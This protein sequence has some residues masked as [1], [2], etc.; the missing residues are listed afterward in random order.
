MP[1]TE[2]QTNDSLINAPENCLVKVFGDSFNKFWNKALKEELEGVNISIKKDDEGKDILVGYITSGW[3]MSAVFI[4]RNL[5]NKFK[6]YR[7]VREQADSVTEFTTEVAM[8]IA[9]IRRKE[10]LWSKVYRELE[11]LWQFQEVTTEQ[12]SKKGQ[13]EARNYQVLS[14]E[15]TAQKNKSDNQSEGSTVVR[16]GTNIAP[17]GK[18][19]SACS[20]LEIDFPKYYKRLWRLFDTYASPSLEFVIDPITGK[21]K[22]VTKEEF[23]EIVE[24]EKKKDKLKDTDPWILLEEYERTKD[25]AKYLKALEIYHS[26]NQKE[27]D[28]LPETSNRKPRI[29]NR[30]KIGEGLV[31][32]YESMRPLPS[33][34][35]F[36]ERWKGEVEGS[37]KIIGFKE[38]FEPVRKWLKGWHQ[39]NKYLGKVKPPRQLMIALLGSPGLGKTYISQKIAEVLGRGFGIIALNGRNSSD[40]IFGSNISNP[41]SDPGEIVKALSRS[42][43]Q[44][45][46][47]LLDEIDKAGLETKQAIGNPTD[48]TQNYMFKDDFYDFPT[49]LDQV[50]FLA[51][52]NYPEQ[53]PDFVADRFDIKITVK[54]YAYSERIEIAQQL[55]KI[56]LK[57]LEFLIQEVLHKTWEELYQ[58][59]N[60]EALLKKALT[61]TYS[62]RGLKDNIQ[63][64]LLETLKTEFLDEDDLKPFPSDLINHNWGFSDR[65]DLDLGDRDRKRAS[66]PYA[67]DKSQPHRKLTD[68][69]SPGYLPS[70]CECFVNNLDKVPGWKEN[71]GTLK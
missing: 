14:N 51:A 35:E 21:R 22:W 52:L 9:E 7:F 57:D 3:G 65:E 61:K 68:P 60:Q 58:Q 10:H 30:V 43:D 59:F 1:N 15:L 67:K 49:P 11:K 66:C 6:Y 34:V 28:K 27:H 31:K 23:E 50:I 20:A 36:D 12:A 47:M 17:L 71:M 13:G 42:K 19:I 54:P 53:L 69:V 16:K 37:E 29:A 64:K 5:F 24:P 40:I 25:R 18:I 55:L 45:S 70:K 38:V 39:A 46:V 44:T 33:L 8:I 2:N 32:A 26:N 41:G 4:A 48:R 63:G 62:I 56:G